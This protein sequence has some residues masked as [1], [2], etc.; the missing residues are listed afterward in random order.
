MGS[1]EPPLKPILTAPQNNGLKINKNNRHLGTD[2][3]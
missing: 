1:T 3:F 2:I